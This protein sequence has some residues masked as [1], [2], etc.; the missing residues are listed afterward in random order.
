[1]HTKEAYICQTN[2]QKKLHWKS[3]I[4]VIL[5][6]ETLLFF[7]RRWN[8]INSPRYF[9][10]LSLSFRKLNAA[11]RMSNN[12]YMVLDNLNESRASDE[13]NAQK[14]K[15]PQ[16]TLDY[17]PWTRIVFSLCFTYA[18]IMYSYFAGYFFFEFLSKKFTHSHFLFL[19]LLKFSRVLDFWFWLSIFG[20]KSFK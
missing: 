3:H 16:N 4:F 17:W 15:R 6:M 9:L 11:K 2:K 7:G 5:L 12:S 19:H 10:S 8:K 13:P 20:V 1:M 14:W 18:C